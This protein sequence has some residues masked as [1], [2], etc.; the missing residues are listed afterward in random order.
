MGN[1]RKPF[2][3]LAL[4]VILVLELLGRRVISRP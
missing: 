1:L 4:L 2:L 3:I